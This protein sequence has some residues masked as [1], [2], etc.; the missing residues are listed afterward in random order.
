MPPTPALH[1][2][3]IHTHGDASRRGARGSQ[4]KAEPYMRPILAKTLVF[5]SC[6]HPDNWYLTPAGATEPE[7]ARRLR[8]FAQI[9]VVSEGDLA[10]QRVAGSEAPLPQ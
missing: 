3:A 1:C 5:T 4:A 2:R 10:A 9:I 6:I 8:D 7:W